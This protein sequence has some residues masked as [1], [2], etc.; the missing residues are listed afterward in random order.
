MSETFGPDFITVTDE[1]GNEF[2]LELVT[3]W[4]ITASPIAP[5]S[6]LLQKTRRPAS[7]WMWTQTMR[8]TVWSS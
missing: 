5:C 8:N 2:E 6:P 1:D 7:P 4:S 3:P